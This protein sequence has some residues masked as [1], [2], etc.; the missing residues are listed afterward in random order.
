MP[1]M[2]SNHSQQFSAFTRSGYYFYRVANSFLG[3]STS[4]GCIYPAL[5]LLGDRE[6]SLSLAIQP[7]EV[8]SYSHPSQFRILY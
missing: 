2:A 5:K 3:F 7:Q 6:T 8:L 4:A 1:V